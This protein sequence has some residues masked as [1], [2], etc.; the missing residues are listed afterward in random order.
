MKQISLRL[1]DSLLEE[2]DQCRGLV[3]REVYIRS[4]LAAEVA[5]ASIVKQPAQQK[6]TDPVDANVKVTRRVI[7]TTL[8][9]GQVSLAPCNHSWLRVDGQSVCKHC[10][11]TYTKEKV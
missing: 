6:V 3:P 7:D 10:G 5:M 11:Q 2:V 8:E 1:T 4:V 9:P